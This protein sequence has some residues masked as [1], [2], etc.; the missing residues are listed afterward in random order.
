MWMR[1]LGQ[2]SS[3]ELIKRWTINLGLTLLRLVPWPRKTGLIEVGQ[4]PTLRHSREITQVCSP[5]VT[6]LLTEE[7]GND[8]GFSDWSGRL[9]PMG[10][11]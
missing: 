4:E 11:S 10:K 8:A 9:L 6:Q 5:K 7:R 2:K 3:M 1:D